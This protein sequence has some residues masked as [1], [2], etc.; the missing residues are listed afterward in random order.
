[1]RRVSV[2]GLLWKGETTQ[3][4]SS[5]ASV[6]VPGCKSS[7][8]VFFSHCMPLPSGLTA[9]NCAI[10]PL[11]DGLPRR[12]RL[13]IHFVLS[14]FT[15]VTR[16]PRTIAVIHNGRI[17]VRRSTGNGWQ[18]RTGLV[19]VGGEALAAGWLGSSWLL[20]VGIHIVMVDDGRI[21]F[22]AQD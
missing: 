7:G 4:P 22:K 3:S 13:R 21:S 17:K 8:C 14:K 19:G 18:E 2:E 10:H 9:F 11:S 15:I 1:M 6:A 12:T 16:W 5:P 20:G